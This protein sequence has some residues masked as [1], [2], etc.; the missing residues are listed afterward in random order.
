M[1]SEV[2]NEKEIKYLSKFINLPGKDKVLTEDEW[3]DIQD[4]AKDLTTE[5]VLDNI[6][7][8]NY[9]NDIA[10]KLIEFF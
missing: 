6:E 3:F 7:D 4:K 2:L 10:D 8:A 1:I 5:H 9:L